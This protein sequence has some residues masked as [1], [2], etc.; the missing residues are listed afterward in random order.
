MF[1]LTRSSS[2]L[3]TAV[4]AAASYFYISH[5]DSLEHES[6]KIVLRLTPESQKS[7]LDFLEERGFKNQKLNPNVIISRNPSK[8][9]T[10]QL[11]MLFGQKAAFR[12]RGLLVEK[13]GEGNESIAVYGRASHFLGEIRDPEYYPSLLTSSIDILDEHVID[14]PTV[15]SQSRPDLLSSNPSSDHQ[16]R[17]ITLPAA[18]IRGISHSPSTVSYIPLAF[19]LQIVVDGVLCGSEYLN[20]E[21]SCMYEDSKKES[22]DTSPPQLS[23]DDPL[24]IISPEPKEPVHPEDEQ[25]KCSL[26]R[27]MRR[28]SCR[29]EF[30]S[31]TK[32]IDAHEENAPTKCTSET[33]TL[34]RCLVKDEY[35]DVMTVNSHRLLPRLEDAVANPTTDVDELPEDSAPEIRN[36][37]NSDSNNNNKNN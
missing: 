26:C 36:D 19:P 15:V 10:T 16:D 8:G 33:L 20:E 3:A 14:R 11:E 27:Y 30:I 28:G 2:R 18:T 5:S 12:L 4:A 17:S 23:K 31:W 7:V 6:R 22:S 35:Y 24:V 21:G 34:F 9:T 32:C 29:D 13:D 1:R 37:S 25:E